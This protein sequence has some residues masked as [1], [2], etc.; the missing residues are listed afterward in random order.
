[1]AFPIT[2]SGRPSLISRT[3][4]AAPASLER[5][6]GS[7]FFA[8]GLGL[9]LVSLV[10]CGGIF[11]YRKYLESRRDSLARE[12]KEREQALQSDSLREIIAFSQ[13][14]SAA[15][16]LLREHP[17]SSNVFQFLQA[18][19]HQ[20][21]QFKSFSFAGQNRRV[22]MNA[23]ARSYRAVAEQ[24]SV[25]EGNPEVE[26]VDFSGLSLA[27][28]VVNFRIGMVLKPSVFKYKTP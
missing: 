4:Q 2:E 10:A 26:S 5:L 28:N 9:F 22:D 21:V 1:M 12:V 27:T 13:S 17:F 20:G 3:P 8:V 23:V 24:I 16:T 11:G 6:A 15:Q 19:T 25:L 7:W 18:N 14:L